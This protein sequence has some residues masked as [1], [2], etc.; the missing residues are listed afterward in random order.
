MAQ[1]TTKDRL[2]QELERPIDRDSYPEL[3]ETLYGSYR[4]VDEAHRYL[5]DLRQQAEETS[6]VDEKLQEK[7]GLL[8]Y[9]LGEYEQAVNY[10]EPLTDSVDAAHF[11]GRSYLELRRMDE[12]EEALEK[13]RRGDDDFDTDVLLVDV[14]CFKREPEPARDICERYKEEHGGSA[15]W[16]YAM[17]RVL[18][19]EGEYARAMERYE[20]AIDLDPEYRKA[21]FRLALNADMNGDDERAIE[22][23]E[24]CAA[25]Q[26]TFLGALINLGILYE[27]QQEFEEAVAC[28]RRVLA[29]D[30]AHRIARLYVKDAEASLEM[31]VDEDKRALMA[32]KE[33][34]RDRPVSDFEFSTRGGHVLDELDIHTLGDLAELD[35]DDLLAFDNFGETSLTEMKQVLARHNLQF[36]GELADAGLADSGL[37]DTQTEEALQNLDTSVETLDLSTRSQQCME[38][39]G[40]ETIGE[41]IEQ[42]EKD[43]LETPNFGRTSVSE[44]KTKLAE[45]G[46]GLR[47]E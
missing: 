40:I 25:L 17:G 44:I 3:V 7:I 33:E 31:V 41:L 4:I 45:L 15:R 42:S 9:A 47:E 35:E 23:Y 20:Q 8:C 13:G 10:L 36:G 37:A 12:A 38:K 30:P 6:Q 18:E 5:E 29:I 43:L 32:K 46:L 21:L 16:L 22:L 39:L 11:L 34:A 26:P 14:H 2:Q 24:D 27:D 1:N 19:T 28:Y